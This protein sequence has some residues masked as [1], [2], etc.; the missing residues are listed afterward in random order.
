VGRDGRDRAT[1]WSYAAFAIASTICSSP[2]FSEPG[3]DQNPVPHDLRLEPRGAVV[4]PDRF[5]AVGQYHPDAVLRDAGVRQL[6]VRE[7]VAGA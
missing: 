4:V 7:D 1:G 5:P 3:I 2:K 6:H